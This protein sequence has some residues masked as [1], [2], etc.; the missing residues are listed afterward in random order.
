MSIIKLPP[1]ILDSTLDFTFNNVTATGN[2][3]AT[4]ANLGNLATANYV[5]GTLDSLSNAQPNITSTG[6][7]TSLTVSG[8]SSVGGNLTITGN[9]TVSGTQTTVNSTTVNINDINIVIANNATTAAQANGAGITINGAVANMVYVNSTNSFT[10]SHKI[11]ADGGLL[12]NITGANITGIVGN[13]THANIADAANSVAV[14]NV[15]GIGNIATINKDGNA[16]NILYGNGVF[17]AAPAGG[18]GSSYTDSNVATYL[19]TYTGNISPGNLII[20]PGSLKISGGTSG[21]V[22]STDGTGNVSWAAQSG[23]S[24]SGAKVTVSSTAPTSASQGDMWFDSETGEL[25]VYYVNSWVSITQNAPQLSSLVDSFTGNGVATDFTL[26]SV[27]VSINYTFVSVGGILQPRTAYSITGNVLSFTSAVPSN[28]PVDVTVLGG[29]TTPISAATT[30]ISNAQPNITSVGTLTSLVVSGN[31]T[32]GNANLGNLVTANY[33]TGNGSLLS[34]IT[35]ANVTGTVAN[36]TYATSA[37]TA[38]TAATVT[39]AAQPNITSHGTL[40]GLA[41]SGN[42]V[43]SGWTTLQQS[44]EVLTTK[45]GATGTVAHDMTTGATFYHT[46]PAANFT[47]NF[48]NVSTTDNRAI[49]TAL[50]IVQGSTPYVPTAVQIDGTAQ[51]IKWLGSTAPTGTASKTDVV[52]FTLM[53]VSSAWSVYGQYSSYG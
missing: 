49:V 47:A 13:A 1:Y 22:L 30:V 53:R 43:F 14:G 50:V 17:A 21:Y 33:Y 28:S 10:F 29:S 27:P 52:S 19:P 9:L 44:S 32:S 6:T 42:S 23:G 12:S 4:N 7:L 24:G 25:N 8:D 16:S 34:A 18:G 11:S 36:A 38:T 2:L 5:R 37:G 51:T 20:S 41:V 40:T 39:T 35:G 3:V 46:S 26:S 45:T 15:T 31:I 48:T